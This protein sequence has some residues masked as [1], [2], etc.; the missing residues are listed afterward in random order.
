MS[1]RAEWSV[2]NGADLN[3]VS[4][5]TPC[6]EPRHSAATSSTRDPALC[7]QSDAAVTTVRTLM[8]RPQPWFPNLSTLTTHRPAAVG[9]RSARRSNR[10]FP[11]GSLQS[12]RHAGQISGVVVNAVALVVNVSERAGGTSEAAFRWDCAPQ[13]LMWAADSDA[14]LMRT[15]GTAGVSGGEVG[16]SELFVLIFEYV[17]HLI[18][19]TALRV[20]RGS[21]RDPGKASFYW[22]SCCGRTGLPSAGG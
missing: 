2:R 14:A 22:L 9:G 4:G 11:L 18:G 17:C 20:G 7:F 6:V 8:I 19:T 15:A 10:L 13:P 16:L 1:T 5:N 3:Q 21:F 12:A